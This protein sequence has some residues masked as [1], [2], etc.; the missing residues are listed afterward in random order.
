MTGNKN[1]D[2]I[3]LIISGLACFGVLGTY[4]YTNVVY[5]RPLPQDLVEKAK[6]LKDAKKVVFTEPYKLDKL[7]IN[8][9]SRTR[10]LRFLDV[11]IHLVP[12][13]SKYNDL[14]DQ[15]KSTISDSII[16]LAGEME[17]EEL[18]SISGKLLLEHRIK[19]TI[20]ANLGGDVIKEV[21]FS[22]F[23]VQ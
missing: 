15:N 3:I 22:K 5:E 18:N 20:N 4:I 12:F 9:Q 2:Y 8:L 16:N 14:L 11:E 19:E 6:L 1:L 17:P 13:K 10:R 7:T 23:I 21:L